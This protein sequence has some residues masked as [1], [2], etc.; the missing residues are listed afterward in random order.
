[1]K[2][3]NKQTRLTYEYKGQAKSLSFLYSTSLGRTC[4]KL[5]VKPSVSKISGKFLSTKFST[6]MIKSFVK[7]NHIDLSEYEQRKF[8]SYNDFFTRKILNDKRT[9]DM[10]KKAFISPCDAKLSAYKINET[11]TFKIKDSYYTVKDLLDR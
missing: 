10:D 5:L 2:N 3:V 4:L 1:M 9:V 8:S 11:S 7:K 6:A